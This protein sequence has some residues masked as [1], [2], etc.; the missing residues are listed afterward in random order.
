MSLMKAQGSDVLIA[1][2]A[3]ALHGSNIFSFYVSYAYSLRRSKVVLK[4]SYKHNEP[5]V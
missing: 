3:V 4:V 1:I 2:I 5:P